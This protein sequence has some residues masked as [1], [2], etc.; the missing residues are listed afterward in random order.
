MS[1]GVIV[2][3]CVRSMP[4]MSSGMEE[5]RHLKIKIVFGTIERTCQL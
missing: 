1:T 5:F 3:F 4:K 2:L